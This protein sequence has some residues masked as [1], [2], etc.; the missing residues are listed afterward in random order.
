[1]GGDIHDLTVEFVNG[2]LVSHHDDFTAVPFSVESMELGIFMG[3]VL[4]ATDALKFSSFGWEL[5]C[6][7]IFGSPFDRDTTGNNIAGMVSFFYV[8]VAN[9]VLE[10]SGPYFELFDVIDK[11]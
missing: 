2:P 11:T 3:G 5:E 1:M 8:V 10:C 7:S 9:L 4:G 6:C